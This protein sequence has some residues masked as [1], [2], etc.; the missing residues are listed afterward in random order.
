[1]PVDLLSDRGSPWTSSDR[2]LMFSAS[3]RT[4]ER[5]G[6]LVRV[7]DDVAAAIAAAQPLHFEDGGF[8]WR[9]LVA[10]FAALALAIAAA[11]LLQRLRIAPSR[12]PEPV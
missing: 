11:L 6:T 10:V 8:A 1:M 3:A 2:D 9:T 5:G 4:I 7:D 12:R